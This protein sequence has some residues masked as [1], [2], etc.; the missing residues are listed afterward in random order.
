MCVHHDGTGNR[1]GAARTRPHMH[2]DDG[3]H[4]IHAAA[5]DTCSCTGQKCI[6]AGTFRQSR[7]IRKAHIRPP[8]AKV[9]IALI[10]PQV[11]RCMSAICSHQTLVL[12]RIRFIGRFSR[13]FDSSSANCSSYVTKLFC[14]SCSAIN[15]SIGPSDRTLFGIWIL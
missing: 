6:V 15:R 8:P 11:S 4:A 5:A 12:P 10:L 9:W 14:F 1:R 2:P 13:L 7:Q 3:H